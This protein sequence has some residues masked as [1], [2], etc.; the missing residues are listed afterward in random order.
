MLAFSDTALAHLVIAA[1]AVPRAKRAAALRALARAHDPSAYEAFRHRRNADWLAWKARHRRGSA[2]AKV[3]YGPRR[4]A[5]LERLGLVSGEHYPD[6]GTI[7]V[8]LQ[9]LLDL[10]EDWIAN[11]PEGA[12]WA[13]KIRA[14]ALRK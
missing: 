14:A 4:V 8:A 11:T 5:L 6:N 12:R 13:A 9:I 10:L 1:T 2:L 3:E 7:G